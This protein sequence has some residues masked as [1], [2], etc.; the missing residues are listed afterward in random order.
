M[1][2]GLVCLFSGE[3]R[4]VPGRSR[5]TADA[6]ARAALCLL[7]R[8]G[9]R[10]A[11]DHARAILLTLEGRRAAE[12]A[13][14]LRVHVSTVREWRGVVFRGGVGALRRPKPSRRPRPVGAAAAGP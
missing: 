12:I 5:I 4:A 13:T 9:H 1:D 14:A 7:A 6:E 10:A 11:A 3:R 8:S 2:R